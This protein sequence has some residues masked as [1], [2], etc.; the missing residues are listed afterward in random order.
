M[1]SC[2]CSFKWKKS[3]WTLLQ[4]QKKIIYPITPNIVLAQTNF[5]AHGRLQ[6]SALQSD[7]QI[8]CS[9]STLSLRCFLVTVPLT[10][11]M[12]QT[13]H[14]HMCYVWSMVKWL[15][16]GR[17]QYNSCM[18]S[19][20]GRQELIFRR[21]MMESSDMTQYVSKLSESHSHQVAWVGGCLHFIKWR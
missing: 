13:I 9:C 17:K 14:I 7:R 6:S 18:V 1:C 20:N 16:S 5:S 10:L 3:C 11:F 4:E 8:Q 15:C 12:L 21:L 19:L 2:S